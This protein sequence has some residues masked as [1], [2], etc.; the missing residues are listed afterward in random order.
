MVCPCNFY[1]HEYKKKKKKKKNII[2]KPADKGDATVVLNT[3]DNHHKVLQILT[4]KTFYKQMT[5]SHINTVR[6]E[7]QSLIDYLR[8]K[9]TIDDRPFHHQKTTQDTTF[10][11]ITQSTQT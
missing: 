7:V 11:R 6:Q 2:I 3:H 4:Y 10:L 5:H 9:G 1:F 8:I